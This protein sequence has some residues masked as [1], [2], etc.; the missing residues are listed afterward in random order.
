MDPNGEVHTPP[1]LVK[2]IYSHIIP[3][4]EPYEHIDLYEPGVGPGIFQE[5]YPFKSKTT[6]NG[7]DIIYK[8]P[9]PIVNGDFFDQQLKQYDIILGNL[10][11]NKGVVHTPCNKTN[12]TKSKTIWPIMLKRCLQHIKPN[13]Y[14]AFIIPCIWLK[15]DKENIYDELTSR[16]ILFLKTYDCVESNKLFHYKC[17][18]PICYVIF[19]NIFISKLTIWDNNTFIDFPLE[20]N[21]C[22]PTKNISLLKKSIQYVKDRKRLSPI[23]IANTKKIIETKDGY[24]YIKSITNTINGFYSNEYSSYHSIP[25]IILSNKLKPIP[26]KDLEGQYGLYGRDIY[27]F[28]GEDL[29]KIYDFLCIPIIQTIIKSFTIRMNFYEKYIFDYLPDPRYCDVNEYISKLK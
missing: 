11:F 8:H 13:G 2:E 27:I 23:K 21:H 15:P 20:L 6:Y 28:I 25:K 10:P 18:T 4:L 24:F 7:C 17:Q 5:L 12:H 29:E 14:G 19:Q 3:I 1:H 9:S 26:F 16:N 22:I